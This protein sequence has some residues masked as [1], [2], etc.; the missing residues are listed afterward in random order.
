MTTEQRAVRG[1]RRTR[2]WHRV[3]HGIY[4][5]LDGRDLDGWTLLLPPGGRFTHLTAAAL[6]GWWLPPL[7]AGLPVV[8]A[9]H[10]W[11]KTPER[12]GLL[13][14]RT[15]GVGQPVTRDGLGL[16]AP[17]DVLI[18]LARDLSLLDLVAVLD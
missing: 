2:E 16:D 10:P 13:V 5:P 12:P 3:S 9:A 4:R 17:V 11:V 14:R 15:V 1:H 8:A 18:N 6:Y 7:P